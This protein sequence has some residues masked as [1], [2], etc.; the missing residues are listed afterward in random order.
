MTEKVQL[1]S[2]NPRLLDPPIG[3]QD[4]QS[5]INTVEISNS[6]DLGFDSF[7]EVE[8]ILFGTPQEIENE[9]MQEAHEE[10]SLTSSAGNY[11][12]EIGSTQIQHEEEKS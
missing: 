1:F 12:R 11:S 9:D 8:G 10:I 3:G 7:K 2:S 6:I 4:Y 5:L